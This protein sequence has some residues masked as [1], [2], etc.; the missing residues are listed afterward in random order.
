MKSKK[1]ILLEPDVDDVCNLIA[2]AI[3]RILRENDHKQVSEDDDDITSES[4]TSHD[5]NYS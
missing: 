3:T 5:S 2:Q 1:L 4:S